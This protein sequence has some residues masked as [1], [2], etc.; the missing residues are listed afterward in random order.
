MLLVPR[1]SEL[2]W[3]RAALNDPSRSGWP[4]SEFLHLAPALA[5]QRSRVLFVGCGGGVSLHQ[6]ASNYPGMTLDLVEHEPVVVKLA[7]DWF[8]LNAIPQLTVHIADGVEFIANAPPKTWDAIVLDAYDAEVGAPACCQPAFFPALRRALRPGGTVACNLIGTLGKN[9]P[10]RDFI[11]SCSS[12]FDTVRI[13]PVVDIHEAY[14][15][16]TVR[17]VVVIAR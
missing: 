12:V 8:G 9:G 11:A 7:Q 6:F 1:T 3:S 17:N 16:D 10:V 15:R 13:V 14:A 5:S 2:V 4:Y